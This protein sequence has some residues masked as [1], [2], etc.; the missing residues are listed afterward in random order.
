MKD[1]SSSK[2]FSKLRAFARDAFSSQ[3]YDYNDNDYYSDEE[4][5]YEKAGSKGDVFDDTE[6]KS[7]PYQSS[8]SSSYSFDTDKSSSYSSSSLSGHSSYSE[9][10][11]KSTLYKMNGKTK[12][13]LSILR[14]EKLDDAVKVAD[15]IMSGNTITLVD[16]RCVQKETVRRIIDF[17]DGVRYTCEA[18]MEIVADYTYVVVPKDVELSGDLFSQI[19]TGSLS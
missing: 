8:Y 3:E 2:R 11:G 14:L 10:S 4:D 19:E 17:L 12:F 5:S 6:K 15:E 7:Y 1:E 9:K 18:K 16:L 13:R